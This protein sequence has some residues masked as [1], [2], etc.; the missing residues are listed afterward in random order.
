MGLA[1]AF[2]VGTASGGTA[3]HVAAL[4]RGCREAGLAVTAF[5][6]A[7]AAGLFGA[8]VA[9]TPVPIGDRP[10]P[11]R[12]LA[13]VALLRRGLRS[14]RPD[15]VHAHGVRA[16]GFAVL[17]L[18]GR[19]GRA[20]PALAV[21]V[22]NAPPA[23]NGLRGRAARLVYAMLE[24]ACAR[25]ADAV[26]C[27]SA[28]L[29]ERMRSLGAAAEQFD[30][31][32]A[33]APPPSEAAV[34]QAARD[35]GAG[36][37]PVVLAVGRLAPQKGFDTLVS[38]AAAW[39][40]AGTAARTVIAGGGPLAADL[41]SQSD[42]ESADVLLL[43]ERA[44]V[45]ALLAVADVVVVPSRWEARALLVQ[46]AMRAGRPIVA[47]RV[48]GT[49]GL[50]GEDGAILVPPDDPAALAAAVMAVLSDAPLAAR[51]GLAASARAAAFRSED[52]AIAAVVAIY[53][54]L[55]RTAKES[56]IQSAKSG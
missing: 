33:G 1:V 5:G 18:A 22:H 54:R 51:L 4:A 32:A 40:R 17:A 2:V 52:D 43:G 37:R 34:A 31:P 9:V 19:P 36:G 38:A 45:Q 26:L 28:D 53:A 39:R 14:A 48:G 24:R 11:A 35:I 25:R 55:A 56:R 12:D 27:A 10:R 29:A 3:A 42:R 47:T 21:T 8:E 16:G 44:D 7:Q 30:V 49:P 46:E 15:V 23:G 13:S 41:A 20:R 50:T 6:P